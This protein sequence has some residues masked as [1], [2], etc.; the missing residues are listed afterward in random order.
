M[1]F[2]AGIFFCFVLFCPTL[3]SKMTNS[4]IQE[5]GQS[6]S[7]NVACCIYLCAVGEKELLSAVNDLHRMVFLILAL[8]HLG[9][10]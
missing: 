6:V 7:E 9:K 2:W 5:D 10:L 3:H 4:K 1:F 8:L